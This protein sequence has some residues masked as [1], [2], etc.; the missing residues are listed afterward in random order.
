MQ[1]MYKETGGK[2]EGN[3]EIGIFICY[4]VKDDSKCRQIEHQHIDLGVWAA[5]LYP[6]RSYNALLVMQHD[7][8]IQWS[9]PMS[10]D[11]TDGP[12]NR[13]VCSFSVALPVDSNMQNGGI[14][15]QQTKE[16]YE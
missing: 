7:W 6:L 2:R 3:I 15:S 12:E 11:M 13:R 9:F 10:E 4:Y 1:I 16:Q 8:L 14:W 5:A